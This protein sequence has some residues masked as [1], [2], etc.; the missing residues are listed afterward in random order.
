[1]PLNESRGPVRSNLTPQQKREQEAAI[2]GLRP[3]NP[4]DLSQIT[5]EDLEKMRSIVLQHDSQNKIK[6]FDLNNPP[7]E[8]Y[9]HQEFPRCIYHHKKG[10]S[11]VVPTQEELDAHTAKGWAKEPPPPADADG[12][13]VDPALDAFDAAEAADIDAKLTKTKKRG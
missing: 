8:A 3:I 4:M 13:D 6:E 7:K 11:K 9:K 10:I 12:E 2:Y 1:V 5:Q